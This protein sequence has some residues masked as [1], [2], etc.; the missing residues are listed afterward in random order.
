MENVNELFFWVWIVGND[1][2]IKYKV[3]LLQCWVW[4]VVMD[5]SI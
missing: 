4:I 5:F 1:F 3:E 2:N